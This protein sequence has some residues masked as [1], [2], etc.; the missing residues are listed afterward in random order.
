MRTVSERTMKRLAR[1][2]QVCLLLSVPAAAPAQE[3]FVTRGAGSPM[4]SDQPQAGAKPVLLPELNISKPVPIPKAAVPAASRVS[5][6]SDQP[7]AAAP[8][9]HRFSIVEPANDGS[10]AANNALF[11]VRVAM[12]PALQL[13]NGHAITV[14]IN[15]RPVGQRFTANEFMIPPEF[16]GDTL[17]PTN[18]RYQLDAAIV[19]GHGGVLKQAVPVTFYLR[20]LAVWH[21][22]R[23][24][25]PMPVQKP[26]PPP[27]PTFGKFE[28]PGKPPLNVKSPIRSEP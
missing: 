18:Q 4:Y 24:P 15:G 2:A 28:Q 13:G 7:A 22:R 16:W 11:E 12:E 6:E 25:M 21:P 1:L 23:Q 8:A 19:D 10:V 20:H 5:R 17:P 26:P 27:P 14:S 9:Y 3:V